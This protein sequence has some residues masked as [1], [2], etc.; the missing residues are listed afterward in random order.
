MELWF[1]KRGYPENMIDEEMKKVKFLEK[2]SKKSEGFKGVSFVVT[3]H[4]SLNC[5][6][7]IIKDSLNISDMSRE[8]KAV[9]SPGPMILFRSARRISSYLVK[10]K[11]YPLERFVGSR[12]CKK[13]QMRSLHC[14]R[15]R[16]LY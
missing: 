6:S 16:Y 3:Y 14:H 11:L 13:T 12:Q 2:G 5:L 15:N 10:A 1:L 8:A 4:P 7:R 9:F